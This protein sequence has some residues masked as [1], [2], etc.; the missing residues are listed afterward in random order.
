M[1][2]K[3]LPLKS[4][5]SY[6]SG[7]VSA[8]VSET[9][10]RKGSVTVEAAMAVPIFFLAVVSLLYLMEIMAVTSWMLY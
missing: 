9:D 6:I 1:N 8:S 5:Y 3:Q 4:I 2:R 10:S 7:R